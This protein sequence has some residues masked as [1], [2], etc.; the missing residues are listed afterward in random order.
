[1]R[2]WLG[3]HEVEA[4]LAV[5]RMQIQ[6][7]MMFRTNMLENEG[8]LFI[9][10]RPHQTGFYMKN[11][12]VPLSC[13]YI[14]TEGTIL[15]IHDMQPLDEASIDAQSDQIQYVLEVKQGWF[16]RKNVGVGTVVRTEHGSLNDTFFNRQ[17][18]PFT[19]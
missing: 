8:M 4:E 15:E 12:R 7:G 19:E 18:N 13:A 17:R 16:Q 3:P 2:L 14:D 11:T 6:T 5:T 1:M 10:G 9:F